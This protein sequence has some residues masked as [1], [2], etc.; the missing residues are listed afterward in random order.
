LFSEVDLEVL[1]A[2]E[3]SELEAIFL[4][5]A[6][7]IA[8]GVDPAAIVSKAVVTLQDSRRRELG[9]METQLT[10]SASGDA[11]T[12][13]AAL[14]A[15]MLDGL[16]AAIPGAVGA[17]SSVD[18]ALSSG[19]QESSSSPKSANIGVI[20]GAVG[21]G[22]VL[23]MVVVVLVKRRS[24]APPADHSKVHEDTA[25]R[26]TI[27]NPL[28]GLDDD[29][30]PSAPEYANEEYGN[31]E[32]GD[33]YEEPVVMD[34]AF[35]DAEYDEM[36]DEDMDESGYLDVEG[37]GEDFSDPTFSALAQGLQR[38]NTVIVERKVDRIQAENQELRARMDRL[39][40]LVEGGQFNSRE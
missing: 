21:A 14:N 36:D 26:T 34:P 25:P 28:Y 9:T 29:E 6:S 18:V 15:Q 33:L 1:R 24:V 4:D 30:L 27:M 10:M 12:I 23:L 7:D 40:A 3:L 39:A 31:E 17:T 13:E 11:N 22:L 32:D 2:M 20:A 37:E 5:L 35:L 19:S 16:R 8:E 38:V